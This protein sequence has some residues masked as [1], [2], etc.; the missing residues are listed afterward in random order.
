VGFEKY[1]AIFRFGPGFAP[2]EA[3]T[4]PAA[5]HG[6]PSAGGPESL[7]RLPDGRFVAIAEAARPPARSWPKPGGRGQAR[8]GLI[9]SGDPVTF[10]APARFA[11][12]THGADDVADAAALPD[13]RLLV[14]E[15]GFS[16]PFRFHN[17]L[18][19]VPAG[20]IRAH[21]I[22]TG[23]TIATLDEPLIHDNFEGVAVTR[24]GADTIVW[25]VSDDNGTP[26]LQRTL[27]L[28]FKL[29]DR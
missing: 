18:V 9:W 27:L 4:S 8:Q 21:A 12:V 23:R 15:R 2:M 19:L 14:L 1:N 24:E 17:R 6:W 26:L 10:G 16:P 22:V 20:A 29:D 5:M 13:G 7:V 25:L 28:R 3:A 11:Y